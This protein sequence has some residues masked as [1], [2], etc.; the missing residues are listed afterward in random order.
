MTTRVASWLKAA[1][2]TGPPCPLSKATRFPKVASHNRAVLS[3]DAVTIL[4]PVRAKRR[5]AHGCLVPADCD[6]QAPGCGV[7]KSCNVVFGGGDH[8]PPVRAKDRR[9]DRT[10]V[11]PKRRDRVSGVTIPK[12]CGA[13]AGRCND[14]GP[15]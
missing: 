5:R 13:I 12:S 14:L 3:S 1:E 2:T 6:D 11:F 15:V 10:F 4:R 9:K 8:A 7:P